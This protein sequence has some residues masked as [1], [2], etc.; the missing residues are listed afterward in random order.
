[1]EWG[2]DHDD[3]TELDYFLFPTA[4]AKAGKPEATTVA[5]AAA[6][7]PSTTAQSKPKPLAQK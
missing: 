2:A 6:I 5:T 7:T 1:M 3:F 4:A